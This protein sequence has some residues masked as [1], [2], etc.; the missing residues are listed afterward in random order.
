M[1]INIFYIQK[2]EELGYLNE[3]Y[4]KRITKYAALKENNLFNKKIATAQNQDLKIAQKSYEEA[5]IP[6][7]KGFCVVLD[8]RGKELSSMEF[9]QLIADKSDLRFF[10][11]GAYG[12]SA[13]FMRNFDLNLSLS[14]L[15]L[16]H[17]FVRMLL[18]EQI[19]RAFC[20]RYNHPY[21]K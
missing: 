1:Q 5:F 18:L 20:L 15:T 2:N 19:Y 8:E 17:H 4:A 10:I 13:E 9:A 12:L 6:H 16:A 3:K 11:G 7:K 21:H 14:R